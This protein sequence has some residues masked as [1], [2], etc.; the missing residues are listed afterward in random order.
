MQEASLALS[1]V[2]HGHGEQVQQ[3]LHLLATSEC[4]RFKRVWV[5]VNV[6]ETELVSMEIPAGLPVIFVQN[7]TP[8]GFGANHNQA[9]ANEQSLADAAQWFVVL[10]PDM[11]WSRDPFPE[12]C[13]AATAAKTGCVYPRQ[14]STTGVEQDHR[15]TLPSPHAL[16]QRYFGLAAKTVNTEPDWVNAAFLLFPSSVYASL[17]GFDERYH[18]YCEDVD[19]SLRLRLAGWQL[20]E[21]PAVTVTHDARRASR[22]EW[23][24]FVWHVRSLLRLWRSQ[25]YRDFKSRRLAGTI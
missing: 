19:L 4:S 21:C 24:H 14:V 18:M 23:R 2:S 5:T 25:P 1:V 17:G 15:R 10:N 12:M 8:L 16:W 20:R 7:A 13:Q 6:P 9:F 11:F 22:R 3:L